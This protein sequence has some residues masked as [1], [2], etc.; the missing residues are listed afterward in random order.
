MAGV[1]KGGRAALGTRS[2]L[3]GLVCY[4]LDGGRGAKG[5]CGM[6]AQD[7]FAHA[8]Q[9]GFAVGRTGKDEAYGTQ[10]P[11]VRQRVCGLGWSGATG[12]HVQPHRP[13]CIKALVSRPSLLS[14]F[15]SRHRT[16]NRFCILQRFSAARFHNSIRRE[17]QEMRYFSKATVAVFGKLGFSGSCKKR[18]ARF[19]KRCV[20]VVSHSARLRI[21]ASPVSQLNRISPHSPSQSAWYW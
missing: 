11:P 3:Q 17:K 18:I 15:V 7:A 12:K 14:F 4:T 19:A 9:A 21:S 6:A 16:E 10:K 13:R 8:G 1:S 20:F 2:C 5:A